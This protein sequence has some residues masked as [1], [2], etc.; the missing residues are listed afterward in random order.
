MDEMI[1]EGRD[2]EKAQILT[3]WG[4]NDEFSVKTWGSVTEGNVLVRHSWVRRMTG[5]KKDRIPA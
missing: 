3:T 2:Q 1:G 5:K 4:V